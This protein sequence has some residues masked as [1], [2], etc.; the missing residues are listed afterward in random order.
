[1]QTLTSIIMHISS[2]NPMFDHLLE[3]SHQGNRNEWSNIEFDEEL[4]EV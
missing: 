1:M 3:L 4:K 2:P